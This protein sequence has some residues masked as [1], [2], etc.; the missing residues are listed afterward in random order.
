MCH[1]ESLLP[2]FLGA[3]VLATLIA[4]AACVDYVDVTLNDP[5]STPG[6]TPNPPA[7]V[8][9]SAGV[10]QL[11]L[12]W[13]ANDVA[14]AVRSY[15]AY[16]ATAP[17]TEWQPTLPGATTT[18]AVTCC[19]FTVAVPNETKNWF[20]LAAVNSN[21]EGAL[22]AQVL[23]DVPGWRG[24]RQFGSAG[25]E[26]PTGL[27][28]SG[29]AG[30]VTLVGWTDGSLPGY[31]NAG[32]RDL[33]VASFD[34]AGNERWTKQLGTSA[35]DVATDV[36]MD[37]TGAAYVVGATAGALEGTN[38]GSNDVFVARFH[39]D[40]SVDWIRQFGTSGSDSG[41]DIAIGPGGAIYVV[42]TTFGSLD[43]ASAGSSDIFLARFDDSGNRLWTRQVG[44]AGFDSGIGVTADANGAF[45]VGQ[46]DGALDGVNAGGADFVV[47]HYNSSGAKQWTKQ[48]G[49]SGGESPGD[50]GTDG[51]GSVYVS[52]TTDGGLD[53][54]TQQGSGDAFVVKYSASGARI[55][56]MQ[57]GTAG[58]DLARNVAAAGDSIFV[59]GETSGAFPGE[60]N[61]GVSDHFVIQMS[62]SGSVTWIRQFGTPVQELSGGIAQYADGRG[63]FVMGRT[64]GMLDGNMNSGSTDLYLVKYDSSGTKQ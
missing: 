44:S 58:G 37:E 19:A 9:G 42:G 28:V 61:V 8:S 47:V 38:Q 20:A 41:A 25:I 46:T 36:T 34:V 56:T 16:G 21:G 35:L 64:G 40:G 5:S 2:P 50:I 13:E 7:A 1:R 63:I 53:G 49:S 4:V 57:V 29:S 48:F 24:T 55:W 59:G 18:S 32:S 33:V 45:L 52:G 11:T 14:E 23:V 54:F 27:A 39:S 62:S 15:T 30:L 6:P 43:G 51:F 31:V 26:E 3:S 17:W 10:G 12:T 22:S 60:A